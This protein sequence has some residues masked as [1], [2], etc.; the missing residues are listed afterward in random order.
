MIDRTRTTPWATVREVAFE[1]VVIVR[2]TP[3]GSSVTGVRVMSRE[4]WER[5][6]AKRV[7]AEDALQKMA[8]AHPL[9]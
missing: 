2:T 8:N 5:A 3:H 9:R 7:R 6:E 1:D 4:E